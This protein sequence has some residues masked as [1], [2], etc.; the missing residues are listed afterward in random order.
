MKINE[1]LATMREKPSE[2]DEQEINRR[3]DDALMKER[4]LINEKQKTEIENIRKHYQ[5]EITV[6]RIW[7]LHPLFRLAFVGYAKISG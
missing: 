6:N 3:I 7:Q 2:R 5:N 1:S 4:K